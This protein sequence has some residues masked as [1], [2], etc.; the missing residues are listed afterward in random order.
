VARA[1]KP[2]PAA[3]VKRANEQSAAKR[4]RLAE[5]ARA[6]IDLVR[7]RK[8]EITERFYDMGEALVRLQRAGV[9]ESIGHASFGELC[10]KELAISASKA[11]QLVAIVRGVRRADAV[12]WGQDR[13][14]ALLALAEATPEPDS[15]ALLSGAETRLPSGRALDVG[16]ATTT[17]LWDAAR[18]LRAARAQATTKRSRGLT[19]TP[20]ERAG[21]ARLERALHDAGLP[22]ARVIP[23][24]KNRAG[25]QV[26]IERVPLAEIDK[27]RVALTQLRKGA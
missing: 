7:R 21:A 5:E 16:K 4:R 26:R 15:A 12:K 3:L 27:V 17:A 25:A 23:V 20:E 2:L 22:L 8:D 18:E 11:R 14:A 6:D 13:A 10:E 19:T 24:A 1:K 9:A